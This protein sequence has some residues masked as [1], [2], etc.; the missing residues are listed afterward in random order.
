MSS[1]DFDDFDVLAPKET[2][3]KPADIPTEYVDD[4]EV[5]P[6]PFREETG[7]SDE[8]Y[9][10]LGDE[11][12]QIANDAKN[13]RMRSDIEEDERQTEAKLITEFTKYWETFLREY[14]VRRY[15]GTKDEE[16]EEIYKYIERIRRM[17][18]VG[19][20][21]EVSFE[22]L[23]KAIE[24]APDTK[25][26]TQ[27]DAI[28][29]RTDTDLDKMEGCLK[30]A[31]MKVMADYLPEHL[32]EIDNVL[33]VGITNYER[34]KELSEIDSLDVGHT[35]R[36]EGM[37]IQYDSEKQLRVVQSAWRCSEGH[38]VTVDGAQK[39]K[40]CPYDDNGVMLHE[41]IEK[42]K[43]VDIMY[44]RIQQKPEQM[45]EGRVDPY[46]LDVYFEGNAK[47]T[48]V[49]SSMSPGLPVAVN[50][51]ILPTE[52]AKGSPDFR[53]IEM[54]GT[55]LEVMSE[56]HMMRDDPRLDAFVRRE[57]PR[58][59]VP[60]DF[61]KMCRSIAPHLEGLELLK[62]SILLQAI[63]TED[64]V[65]DVNGQPTRA[66]LNILIVASPEKGK[67]ELLKFA[68]RLRPRSEYQVATSAT[69]VGLTAGVMSVEVIRQGLRLTSKRVFFG[70]YSRCNGGLL[71]LDEIE[72]GH[73][74]YDSLLSPMESQEIPLSKYGV[75]GKSIPARVASLHAAN[76]VG[77]DTRGIYNPAKP[78]WNQIDL[79]GAMLSRY[80]LV[81]ALKDDY[82][83]AQRMRLWQSIEKSHNKKLTL[84][85][86]ERRRK[87]RDTALE[88]SD[89]DPGAEAYTEAYMRRVIIYLRRMYHPRI[90]EGSVPWRMMKKF[91]NKYN[92]KNLFP[93]DS[94][95]VI[96]ETAGIILPAVG[97]RKINTLI[98]LAEASAR[99]HRRNNVTEYDM[100]IAINLVEDTLGMLIPQKNNAE[101]IA[102]AAKAASGIDKSVIKELSKKDKREISERRIL[103][104]KFC[105]QLK[106]QTF[107][108]CR[109]CR[110]VGKIKRDNRSELM[111]CASCQESKGQYQSFSH[112]QLRRFMGEVDTIPSDKIDTLLDYALDYKIVMPED[113]GRMRVVVALHSK[114]FIN[115]IRKSHLFKG[116][117]EEDEEEAEEVETSEEE[118]SAEVLA[119]SDI[120]GLDDNFA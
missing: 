18:E 112:G 22:D 67:T 40:K 12:E 13:I 45:A 8:E 51:I 39:P 6:A 88:E 111:P 34:T 55:T 43:V 82:S 84:E 61:E 119:Q 17:P 11:R 35:R 19:P 95:D 63:G 105:L 98:R 107:V 4:E 113:K 93:F 78:F 57:I 1:K 70:A 106:A 85:E 86:A 120:K 73:D 100:D 7:L 92:K 36:I 108:A 56:M 91:W 118:M 25:I 89:L 10:D 28:R 96:S 103:F 49:R 26:K 21:F 27:Y 41:V 52:S 9:E 3:D 54:H 42:Q 94:E 53:G 23:L 116:R 5:K 20:L 74:Y 76:P 65:V 97:V 48:K 33:A 87:V 44:I 99:T 58:E 37:V 79:P 16:G 115:I 60:A 109:E 29:R 110:G 64:F 2:E 104:T 69:P 47:V 14:K 102:A 46:E 38:D 50:G 90:E 66:N 81:F 80:D 15:K 24:F 83:D 77:K 30:K 71:S 59:N 72:K 75:S 62:E 32:N 68:S 114:E 117:D 31:L 101:T